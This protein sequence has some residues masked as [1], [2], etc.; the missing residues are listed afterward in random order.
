[1]TVGRRLMALL[2]ALT[3][4]TWAAAMVPVILRW[5]GVYFMPAA[6]AP[7][8]AFGNIAL[9]AGGVLGALAFV[10]MMLGLSPSGQRARVGLG[11]LLALAFGVV[12]TVFAAWMTLVVTVPMLHAA[13]RGEA[14]ALPF[15]VDNPRDHFSRRGHC[16]Q[17]I[18]VEAAS[19]L[20]DNVCGVPDSLREGLQ[21]GQVVTLHGSGSAWG[22]FY[23]GVSRRAERP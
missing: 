12:I 8:V 22:V 10:P 2:A 15:R 16:R 20:F 13:I 4:L 7:P 9:G 21:R 18:S 23:S 1:M 19:F 11:M 6:D 5:V 3:L 14:V 17:A